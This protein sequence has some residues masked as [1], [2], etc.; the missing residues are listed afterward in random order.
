MADREGRDEPAP[1]AHNG[2][3]YVDDPPNV[4]QAIDGRTGELIWETR[5]GPTPNFHPM[6]GSAIYQDKIWWPRTK[7]IFWRWMP[8]TGKFCGTP[9]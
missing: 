6:R 2:V 1:I 3:L 7:R 5:I 9:L 8:G 4:M